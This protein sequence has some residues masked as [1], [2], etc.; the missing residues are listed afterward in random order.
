MEVLLPVVLTRVWSWSHE[1]QARIQGPA[2]EQGAKLE[3]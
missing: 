3:P 1:R 2:Q